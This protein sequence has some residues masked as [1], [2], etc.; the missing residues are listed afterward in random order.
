[1][2]WFR[3]V[4]VLVAW[5]VAAGSW[6]QQEP[7]PAPK[8]Q[9][10]QEQSPSDEPAPEPQASVYPYNR[11][12]H[13]GYADVVWGRPVPVVVPPVATWQTIWGQG[14]GATQIVPIYAQYQGPSGGQ[15]RPQFQAFRPMP[16]WPTDTRQLGA[17]Y[18][19]GPWQPVPG[20]PGIP[21]LSPGSE[22]LSPPPILEVGIPRSFSPL[23]R[24]WRRLWHI[25][26]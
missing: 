23:G 18:I 10:T 6:A 22:Y 17:Y 15:S 20:V 13:A 3:L 11:Q 7:A 14:I 24:L 21:Q 5:A 2:R 8:E 26:F 25:D 12:W 1:M 4:L 16:Y 19:R 9:K